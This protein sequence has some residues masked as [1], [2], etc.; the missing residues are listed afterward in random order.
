MSELLRESGKPP[1]NLHSA[2]KSPEPIT[3]ELT[4]HAAISRSEG[5]ALVSSTLTP[6]A[7][8]V[9]IFGDPYISQDCVLYNPCFA[10]VSLFKSECEI[11][12]VISFPL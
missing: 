4:P 1:F 12:L 5:N 10:H 9:H 11:R 8:K 3:A 7:K 2:T 6:S